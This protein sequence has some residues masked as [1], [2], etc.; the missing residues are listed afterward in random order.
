MRR[1][2]RQRLQPCRCPESRSLCP[3]PH[4]RDLW[5]R[6]R[7]FRCH[8]RNHSGQS[9][10]FRHF[11]DAEWNAGACEMNKKRRMYT[12]H[13]FLVTTMSFLLR[14]YMT[15]Q[16]IPHAVA[17]SLKGLSKQNGHETTNKHQSMSSAKTKK[18]KKGY[19]SWLSTDDFST[20][21][22]VIAFIVVR[23]ARGSEIKGWAKNLERQR[24]KQRARVIAKIQTCG[25]IINFK[26]DRFFDIV[27]LLQRSLLP[28]LVYCS[29][30]EWVCGLSVEKSPRE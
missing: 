18:K 30:F 15:R 21:D 22:H 4:R 23:F 8:H 27:P 28:F 7:P 19:K 11:I 5:K 10:S 1:R 12:K 26:C 2:D 14:M 24:W 25:H 9:C 16:R 20:I 3:Y 17:D 29:V 13:R 6:H